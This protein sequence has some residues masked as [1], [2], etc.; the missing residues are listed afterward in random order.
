MSWEPIIQKLADGQP[1]TIRPKGQ[2]M[3]PKIRSGEQITIV[4][5]GRHRLETGLIVLAKVKGNHYLHLITA[6]D[7]DRIQI[8]NNHGHING[9]TTR[10]RV[11]GI[12]TR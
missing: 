1:V 3:T 12:V 6:I 11:Y 4:P 7:G 2:S 10:D 5:V 8:S 9:W